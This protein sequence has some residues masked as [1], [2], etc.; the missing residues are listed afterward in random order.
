MLDMI[1]YSEKRK[2]MAILV[3]GLATDYCVKATAHDALAATKRFRRPDG[4]RD[5]DVIVIPDAMRAVDVTP[6]DGDRA[7][8]AL[9]DARALALSS[10]QIIDGSVLVDRR[11]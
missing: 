1:A 9:I 2:R 8:A 6:G 11:S 7:L 4:S 10:Q 3:G 5:V